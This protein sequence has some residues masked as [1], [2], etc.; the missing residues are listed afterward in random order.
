MKY[1]IILG[2]GM[3]DEPIES[4]GGKTPLQAANKPVMDGM[5]KVSEQGIAYTV[6]DNLPA[7]SDVANLSMLGYNPQIYYSGRSPLEALSI[8]VDMKDT[9]IALRCNVVTLSEDGEEYEEKK[10]LDHSAGEIT[11]EEAAILIEAVRKELEDE[12]YKFYPG[13]SYRHLTIWDHGQAAELVPPHDILGQKI[14]SYLPKEEKLREMM[15]KS[16]D[17]L[18][19][20]PINEARAEKGLNKANSIWFWGAGTKPALDDFREKTGMA[21]AMVSAVDLLKGIA[22]GANMRNLDVEGANGG[23]DT[24][25]RGKAMAAVE[26]LLEKND[27][28]AYI[29]VEAPDEMGHQGNLDHKIQ[30]I[31]NLDQQVVKVV[32]E[33]LEKSGEDFRILIGPDHPTPIAIRTHSKDPIPFMIYDSTKEY[34]GQEE[35]S[36]AA[37][38][39][40]GLV[41]EHAYDLMKRLLQSE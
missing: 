41:V 13:V 29:H 32:K 39:N 30:A 10:I 31:E 6:P 11:S 35:Y 19:H 2:D 22:V 33:E 28:F 24:N 36:E 37:A 25:Y 12:E 9:D 15:K 38:R 20:H 17:I 16:F 34:S 5:A 4:I 18:N 14:G 7:G 8:G 27:D 40:T 26:A 3:A 1:V 23:L 21:G